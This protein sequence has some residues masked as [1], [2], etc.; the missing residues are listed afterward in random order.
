MK[1]SYSANSGIPIEE[2]VNRIILAQPDVQSVTGWDWTRFIMCILKDEYYDPS[3]NSRFY[4]MS[5]V[6]NPMIFSLLRP[7]LKLN[8]KSLA[9]ILETQARIAQ[10]K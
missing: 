7:W 4:Q 1:E 3:H 6:N 2:R 9:K 10:R 8:E 5:I